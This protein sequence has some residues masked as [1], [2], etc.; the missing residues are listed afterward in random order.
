MLLVPTSI[1][2]LWLTI[3]G[4]SALFGELYSGARI[5]EAVN[6]NVSTALFVLLDRLPLAALTS[7]LSVLVITIFFVTSS[8]SASL[9]IDIITAGGHSEPPTIQRVFWAST[10]GIVAV[11]LLV[12]GGLSALQTGVITTGLPFALVVLLVGYSLLRGLKQDN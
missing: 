3:F 4:N 6:A 7:G 8:D 9:V 12:G 5:V 10:E 2:F 11:V 1:T